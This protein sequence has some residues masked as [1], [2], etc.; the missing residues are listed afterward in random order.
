MDETRQPMQICL[1]TA[2]LLLIVAFASQRAA[3]ESETRVD[4]SKQI[5]PILV[6]HCLECHNADLAEGGLS[7]VERSTARAG[8]DSGQG[9]KP[10]DVDSSLVIQRLREGS[11]PPGTHK[12]R[13]TEDE[14]QLLATWVTQGAEWPQERTLSLYDYTTLH[15]GGEDWW[16][17][18]P[19]K[20]PEVIHA[21]PQGWGRN[22]IDAFVLDQLQAAG[23]GPSPEADRRTLVRRVY[24]DLI[25]LPP[26]PAEAEEFVADNRDDAYERL[27]DRLLQSPHYGER[28]ARH[29][30]DV[31][32]F[33]ESNGYETNT[34]RANAWHYRDYVVRAL[35]DG[36]PYDRFII[37]QLAGDQVGVEVAT[38]FLVGGPHDEVGIKNIEGQRQQRANDLDDMIAVTSTAFLGLSANC[39]RCHDHKFDP[40]PQREYYAMQ[41][42]FAGVQHG[43]RDIKPDDYEERLRRERQLL[44]QLAEV[45][46]RL[47]GLEPHASLDSAAEVNRPTVDAR[48]NGD[49]FEPV[50][51]RL[52]RFTVLATNAGEPCIDELEIWSVGPDP[53]NVALASFGSV[54]S[55]SG[56][57]ANGTNSIHQL[58]HIN[59]GKYGNSHSWISNEGGQG[60]VQIELP[61]PVVID[62]VLWARDRK[63]VY[64]D[65]LATSYRIEV[66]IEP[67]HWKTVATDQ[68]RLSYESAGSTEVEA[69]AQSEAGIERASLLAEKERIESELPPASMFKAYCGTFTEPPPTPLLYRGDVMQPRDEVAPGGFSAVAGGFQ[70]P[71]NMPE[72]QRRLALAKW[73]A[74]ADNPLT[75]R[76][77]V[78]RLWHYHFGQGIVTT[79]SNFGFQGGKPSHPK[80]LDWLA[81]ELVSCN[82]SLKEMHRLI[83]CSSTYRQAST[84]RSEPQHVDAENRLLWHY[85][86]R[87]L[88]AEAIRDS[89]LQASGV[90]DLRIGG[91]G[92]DAF[93]PNNNYVKVYE[94]K[95]QW[96]PTEWRRMI[97][98]TK[99]RMEQDS[100]FGAFDC[101][102]A[103]QIAPNRTISTTALQAL[104]LM[105]SPF[106]IQQAGL[107]AERLERE[108][109]AD[110]AA[111]VDLG[112]Q[113]AYGRSPDDAELKES[114]GFVTQHGLSAFCRALFNTNEFVYVQ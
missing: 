6:A 71:A 21:N 38:G 98:Q 36:T 17:L 30:L 46:R 99:P 55:A 92:Y 82:W 75:T 67:G 22:P 42:V 57:Y 45:N 93:V 68:D 35:N 112:F 73:I 104:N 26:S 58:A 109:P 108:A 87:R 74:S 8:G 34:L 79:P 19:V 4:F 102:D 14:I 32:R 52:I 97:Y 43:E 72:S 23:L 105:N 39:A 80:L 81:S 40:I 60:W 16:S 96:G 13:P 66:A 33:G 103:S 107:F 48:G 61:E 51:T 110:A 56:V 11:M 50:K 18:Q 62:R 91:Q 70:L 59:D 27:V 85:P 114:L 78:N 20:R 2:S 100:T 113:L 95:R 29:W 64:A 76:V 1:G 84:P 12:P 111:Q 54:A 88:E 65:R 28:W 77:I 15:R 94:P 7:L 49:R 86:V 47:V 69:D 5:A 101:P 25:G 10:S 44:E 24:F 63:G 106:V 37:E 53:R 31:V 90:L 9:I 83:L 41:A 3:A 89:I